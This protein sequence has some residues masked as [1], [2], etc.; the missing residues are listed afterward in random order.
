VKE[1]LLQ[2]LQLPVH[3]AAAVYKE[4]RTKLDT[5]LALLPTHLH[6]AA[7]STVFPDIDTHG[8][9]HIDTSRGRW[10]TDVIPASL[11]PQTSD[12]FIREA[13]TSSTP[14]LSALVNAIEKFP[15]IMELHLNIHR[16]S[17]LCVHNSQASSDQGSELDAIQSCMAA[18]ISKLSSMRCI[19]KLS[20]GGAFRTGSALRSLAT[21]VLP[22]LHA[23]QQFALIQ[24]DQTLIEPCI[25]AEAMLVDNLSHCTALRMLHLADVSAVCIRKVLGGAV[26]AHSKF[27][28]LKCLEL[29][30]CNSITFPVGDT[31]QQ[32]LIS[33]KASRYPVLSAVHMP[34]LTSL[35]LDSVCLCSV[36]T[37]TV[38]EWA[39]RI[40][41][42]QHLSIRQADHDASKA[43]A[44]TALAQEL[45]Y[46]TN[47]RAL[48]LT[49]PSRSPNEGI[50]SMQLAKE[51][52]MLGVPEQSALSQSDGALES[53]LQ[54]C[55]R[56]STLVC[57]LS[58]R[59]LLISSWI[60]MVSAVTAGHN[61]FDTGVFIVKHA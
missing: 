51:R 28:T 27:S 39:Q 46:L 49:G 50:A 23:L 1:T 21:A 5:C 55:A 9:L 18:E 34:H 61:H 20:L 40:R 26:A 33:I 52:G 45:P 60:R 57:T 30:C 59:L 37:P 54:T 7:M 14:V 56:V 3:L 10:S 41:Q 6:A 42:L 2:V 31:M 11:H 12:T 16:R 58:S 15:K 8:V 24:R 38:G 19:T 22:S 25:E 17:E 29:R 47:L 44:V 35:S 32:Q 53:L 36:L 4:A 48:K 43:V 13:C